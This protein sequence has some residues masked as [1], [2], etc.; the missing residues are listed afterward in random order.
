MCGEQRAAAVQTQE[1]GFRQRVMQQ[2]RGD[3][4]TLLSYTQFWLRKG[5]MCRNGV[6]GSVPDSPEGVAGSHRLK[7]ASLE[8]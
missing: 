4:A 3:A 7:R 5:E 6:M 2:T 8:W 1:A